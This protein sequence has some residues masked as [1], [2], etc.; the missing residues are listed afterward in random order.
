MQQQRREQPDHARWTVPQYIETWRRL[1]R[2][3][4]HP[5]TMGALED[6]L[7]ANGKTEADV[8]AVR[9]VPIAWREAEN[10]RAAMYRIDRSWLLAI[11]G[12]DAL[13]L[14]VVLVLGVPDPPL[15]L[16]TIFLVIALVFMAC[17][18]SV[19]FIKEGFHIATYDKVHSTIVA[20]AEASGLAALTAVF[21]H[22]ST[23]VGILVLVLSVLAFLLFLS[24]SV[25][26]KV[27][28]GFFRLQAAVNAP[29]VAGANTPTGANA[30]APTESG[31]PQRPEPP[32]QEDGRG[33]TVGGC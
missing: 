22:T 3:Y 12:L 26:A 23:G 2:A 32:A 24:Y 27:A 18:W 29:A 1:W 16:A 30:S 31:A 9:S 6:Y 28:V 13:L 10:D 20:I 14:P 4:N 19:I 25:L 17:A 11:L 7:R 21:W 5:E 8:V 15:F 33:G